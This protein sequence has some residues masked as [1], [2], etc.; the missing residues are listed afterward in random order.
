M[1]KKN[2]L[3]QRPTEANLNTIK[4]DNS[5]PVQDRCG[6]RAVPVEDSTRKDLLAVRILA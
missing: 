5:L 1:Q 2:L 6:T 3:L 4:E